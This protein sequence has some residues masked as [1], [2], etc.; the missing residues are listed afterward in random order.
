MVRLVKH[1]MKLFTTVNVHHILLVNVAKSM[2]LIHVERKTVAR[3]V[4]VVISKV[5]LS[6]FAITPHIQMLHLALILVIQLT[7]V[8][9]SVFDESIQ[10]SKHIARVQSLEQDQLAN[11]QQINAAMHHDALVGTV[12]L[13][14]PHLVDT[15][16]YVK[17]V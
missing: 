5:L 6:V 3:S 14:I 10:L 13:I 7:A 17:V 12:K 16:A 11:Y 15:D 4:Y 8:L 2:F 9:V 1:L